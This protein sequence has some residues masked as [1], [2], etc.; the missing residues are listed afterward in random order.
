MA[1][2]QREQEPRAKSRIFLALRSPLSALRLTIAVAALLVAGEVRGAAYVMQL[3][4]QR[5]LDIFQAIDWQPGDTAGIQTFGFLVDVSGEFESDT[6]TL[7]GTSGGKHA[8]GGWIEFNE[9]LPNFVDWEIHTIWQPGVA[10]GGDSCLEFDPETGCSQSE[11]NDV[12]ITELNFVLN[13]FGIDLWQ[14]IVD[15]GIGNV[16][17][18]DFQCWDPVGGD[19]CYADV[20]YDYIVGIDDLNMVR[21]NF[22]AEGWVR[23]TPPAT[24]IPEP[25]SLIILSLGL[26][27]LSTRRGRLRCR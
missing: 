17:R 26:F 6:A 23:W 27:A 22:G 7:V 13:A 2:K 18:E 11:F 12:S 4:D 15:L 19:Q 5:T 21:N 1:S 8:P 10:R 9:H 20:N 14:Q 24:P 25:S 16:R 3:S